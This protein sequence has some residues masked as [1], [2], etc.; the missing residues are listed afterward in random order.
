MDHSFET[1][2]DNIESAQEYLALLCQAL[3]EAKQNAEA[4][5]LG[6]GNS[7][8]SRRRDALRLVLYNL[9][10]LEHHVKA[11]RRLLNDLRTL[12]RLLLEERAEVVPSGRGADSRD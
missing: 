3:E 4:D 5:I 11:S 1:P 8:H 9:E 2:F 12:R 7:H 10:K 6:P